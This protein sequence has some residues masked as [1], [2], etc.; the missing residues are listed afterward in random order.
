MPVDLSILS[1]P[2]RKENTNY[3]HVVPIL[4]CVEISMCMWSATVAGIKMVFYAC[5]Q[6]CLDLL[7]AHINGE[8]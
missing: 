5:W 7:C 4:C 8:R 1:S 3:V 6:T 2:V